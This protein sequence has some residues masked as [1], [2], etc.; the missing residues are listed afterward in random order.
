[1]HRKCLALVSICCSVFAGASLRGEV[2]LN[3]RDFDPACGQPDHNCRSAFQ[4]A[5]EAAA[6]AGGATVHLPAGT[7]P[8]DFPELSNDVRTGRPFGIESLISV[9]PGV[10]V[11]GHVDASGVPNTVIEWKITSMPVFLFVGASG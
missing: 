2:Q 8:V 11:Q 7:F 5:F 3:I 10:T 9:P 1:M 4:K 6:K